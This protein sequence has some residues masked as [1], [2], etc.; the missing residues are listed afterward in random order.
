MRICGLALIALTLAALLTP[1]PAQAQNLVGNG[2]FESG[3]SGWDGGQVS[4]DS[5]HAQSACLMVADNSP[6]SSVESHARALIPVAQ[7]RSYRLEVWIR[8][9]VAG[10]RTLVT[11]EQYDLSG[12]WIS[13]RN[14]DFV[15]VAD[16]Q[17]TRFSR[18]VRAFGPITLF[19]R[20]VL[21]PVTWTESG[22]L[23][24][25]A[26]FD[27]AFFG[28]V[29][30]TLTQR[31]TWLRNQGPIRVW[32]SPTEQKVRRDAYP[33]ADAPAE[34]AITLEAARAESE[35]AQL[36]LLPDRDDRLASAIV[37]DL[38]G[39]AGAVIP[40]AAVTV[41]EVAYVKITEPTDYASFTGWMP[42]PLPLLGTSLS[43]AAG[44]QQPLWLTVRVPAEAVPG[45]YNGALRLNFGV[46]Q[47]VEIPLALHVW[48][49]AL[50]R[51]HHLRTAYGMSLDQIDR[52]HHLNS[53]SSL[54]RQVFRLYL[55][56]FAEHRISTCDVL[57]DDAIAISF[58][59]ANWPLSS[60]TS[61]P[62]NPAGGNRVL[63]VRDDR[64]DS[65]VGVQGS[66]AIPV[67]HGPS[68]ALGWRAR[69]DTTRNYALAVNQY[70]SN[71]EWIPGHNIDT[72]RA[73]TG[74]WMQDSVTIQAPQ[75]TAETAFVR[76]TLFAC[77]WTQNGELTGTT[78][79]DDISFTAAGSTSN[80]VANPGFELRPDQ[81]EAAV[82]FGKADPAFAYALETLGMDSFRL[83]LPFFAWGDATGHNGGS[84]LGYSWDTP[85]YETI[86]GKLLR[87]VDDYLA[88]RGWL[89]RAYTYWYDEPAPDDYPFVVR[90]MDLIH[91]SDP[92][93]RRLLTEQYVPDLAGRV[94]IWTPIF[95]AFDVSWAR[96][97]QALGEQV[98]WYVCTGPKSPYPNNFIDHPG[99]EHRL[100]FWMAWQYGVQGDL[101]W[102]TTY[103]THDTVFP[104]PRFQDPWVDPMSYNYAG[105][106]GAW[107][108]GDG[109]L[110][111]PPRGWSEGRPRVEGPTPSIR[112]E[113]IREG[114]EDYE[115][116][117]M[118]RDAADRLEAIGGD[119]A[120][121][122]AARDLV[123]VPASLFS[124]VAS[125]ADDPLLLLSHRRR[126][127]RVL[128]QILPVVRSAA[129]LNLPGG[130]A[131][132]V[133]T[134]GSGGSV[135]T[136][137]AG[138][139][140]TS[141]AAPYGVAVFSFQQ[142][143]VV[144]SEAAVPASPPTSAARMFVDYRARAAATPGRTGD[145]LIDIGTGLAIVNQGSRAAGVTYTLRDAAGTKI[146]EGH[147]EISAG[148][149]FA[150]FVD[151]LHD[152]AP[153][154]RMPA[155]FP[156]ETHF[157]SL[158][159]RSDQPVSILAL[160]LTLNQRNEALLTTTPLADLTSLPEDAPLYFPQFV[161]GGG[162]MTA[163]VLL[164]TADR[165]QTGKLSLFDDAG[166][167]LTVNQVDGTRG[168]VFD[169][170]IQPGGVF[171]F[172]T[173]GFP[174]DA[175]VGWA[176]L[177]PDANSLSPVAAGILSFSRSGIRVSETGILA[178]TPT[179]NAHIYIDQSGHHSTGLAITNPAP[180]GLDLRLKACYPDGSAVAGGESTLTLNAEGHS[181]RFIS[182]FISGLPAGFAGVLD[183][184]SASPFVAL[185]LRSLTNSR[186][187]FLLAT[188]PVADQTRPA[189]APMVF[190]QIADGGGYVTE[191]VLMTAA[192]PSSLILRFYSNDGT[193]LP[194]N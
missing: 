156:M 187:D 15:A 157:G 96:E 91:R 127:A 43:L 33:S 112:W 191:F 45:D 34:G 13:G 47:P 98:W 59:N 58:P 152:V 64:K 17:W 192:E 18:V 147:G 4:T 78:W 53:D 180:A 61:D 21:R 12:K 171:V 75:L 142:N 94:D 121:I 5:P 128:E 139:T 24:G 110:L 136:G 2:D 97:R 115:Y 109:R 107:G 131:G 25:T 50:P 189:S 124:S 76:I 134:T 148:I 164:N 119:R 79:F 89:E 130:A 168:S 1:R 77:P 113:L 122:D 95:P 46:A 65:S 101:Y 194:L 11:L 179:T 176:R 150:K 22:E 72:V 49:F 182:Q 108:N 57:G 10:Q 125:F 172:Q 90:G 137:Y 184:S 165:V 135:R 140:L 116:L 167:A 85:Q 105:I 149:H 186:G 30:E 175:R 29:T 111:Y 60:V 120:L 141:G 86:Y 6:T 73:G 80:L 35:P 138:A 185:T 190:P 7:G 114:I 100:R 144:V 106:I 133:L 63:E 51:E 99:I 129:G 3:S 81:I 16:T 66:L 70:R 48:N 82:D 181:A 54:R 56:D 27:D 146:G 132:V 39:P 23:T 177:M 37:S 20:L 67:L 193:P 87:T 55:Q 174:A 155:N 74:S 84:I 161:D 14:Y 123:S 69:T 38:T 44:I 117:W 178:A 173:D 163:L 160:R 166:E 8:A 159:I 40:A 83:P 104:P 41:R 42:D 103:W 32:R 170:A 28:A 126:V 9:A 92:R 154:F 52:Y 118:L 71:G 68:Y 93:L 145:G 183:I 151:Q 158:D 188:F 31:A 162:Y 19:V 62:E 26:W 143:G 36:V 88:Q 153:D 169:Y 102:D